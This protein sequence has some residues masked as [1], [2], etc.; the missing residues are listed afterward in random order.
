MPIHKCILTKSVVTLAVLTFSGCTSS[1]VDEVKYPN[2]RLRSIADAISISVLSDVAHAPM[3]RFDFK[4]IIS[5]RPFSS[6]DSIWTP[7]KLCQYDDLRKDRGHNCYVVLL[8]EECKQK[9]CY[10]LSID[11]SIQDVP[12]V[13]LAI[14]RAVSNPCTQFLRLRAYG[15]PSVEHP[16]MSVKGLFY[17]LYTSSGLLRCEQKENVRFLFEQQPGKIIIN[18]K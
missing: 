7:E 1:L 17:S 16:D 6:A 2:G 14:R 18:L 5:G 12:D 10:T 15:I 9:A 8:G 4:P 3:N 13:N 11:K